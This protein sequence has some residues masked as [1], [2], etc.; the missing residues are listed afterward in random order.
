MQMMARESAKGGER[1]VNF[2]RG[3]AN[4]G[5]RAP[6]ALDYRGGG[7]AARRFGEVRMAVPPDAAERHEQGAG[8]ERARV[9][10]HSTYDRVRR[11]E[12]LAAGCGGDFVKPEGALVD[13][14][15]RRHRYARAGRSPDADT[16]LTVITCPDAA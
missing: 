14:Y 8:G 1:I 6:A 13:W 10:R 7:A 4:R 2:D 9:D 11:A 5:A 12:H 3:K 15:S 16:D